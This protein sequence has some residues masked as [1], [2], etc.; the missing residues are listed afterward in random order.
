[1]PRRVNINGDFDVWQL[2]TAFPGFANRHMF[3]DMWR[4]HNSAGASLDIARSA[5]VPSFA[6]AGRVIRQSAEI[7]VRGPVDPM[8]A[9]RNCCIAYR[10]EGYEW[11]PLHGQPSALSFWVKSSTPGRYWCGLET[12]HSPWRMCAQSFVVE[13]ADC[14]EWKSV[15]FPPALTTGGWSFTDDIGYVF[16]VFL[17]FGEDF[18]VRPSVWNESGGSGDRARVNAL[19]KAGAAFKITGVQFE[20]GERSTPFEMRPLADE[21]H[22]CQRYIQKSF[23]PALAPA[24]A[25]GWDSGEATWRIGAPGFDHGAEN[26]RFTASMRTAPQMSAFNPEQAN[27]YARC[28]TR[29]YDTPEITF[30]NV[31]P[32]GFSI[33]CAPSRRNEIGDAFGLHWLADATLPGIWE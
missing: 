30:V 18:V 6:E 17:A 1:M 3:A 4:L 14:W 27:A 10:G 13:H 22:A 15:A 33:R 26:I 21:L 23:A 8:P 29:D 2:G 25:A 9:N 16:W 7:V 5:D 20:P 24:P 32:D 19:A 12:G 31:T 28:R 11:A